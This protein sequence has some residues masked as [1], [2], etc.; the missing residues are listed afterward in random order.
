MKKI[1]L[2]VISIIIFGLAYISLTSCN[3]DEDESPPSNKTVK[4]ELKGNYTGRIF[5]AFTDQNGSTVNEIVSSLPWNK[6]ITV[7]SSVIAVGIGGQTSAP[8]Y[9]AVGQTVTANLYVENQVKQSGTATAD[10]NGVI[11]LPNLASSLQ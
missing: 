10:T 11:V 6:E 3:K 4:Y 9:G 7:K 5:V 8:Y 2:L 1:F